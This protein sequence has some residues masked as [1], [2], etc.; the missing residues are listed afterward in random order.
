MKKNLRG[1]SFVSHVAVACGML[2]S[3]LSACGGG[4]DEVSSPTS[5]EHPQHV[6]GTPLDTF[7]AS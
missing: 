7:A 5:M 6:S 1:I 2:L 3:L 4:G